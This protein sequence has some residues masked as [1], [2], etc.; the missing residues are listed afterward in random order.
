MCTR[1]DRKECA[2]SKKKKQKNVKLEINSFRN[3]L[4]LVLV[5]EMRESK[6]LAQTPMQ[7]SPFEP[8]FSRCSIPRFA[9]LLEHEHR[10]A[11]HE[12]ERRCAD[13]EPSIVNHYTNADAK[14]HC[15]NRISRIGVH[16]VS[17]SLHARARG[18]ARGF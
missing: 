7:E 12:H 5:L 8:N 1:A 14:A 10:C 3:V 9:A 16:P 17:Q 15:F 4:V 2:H 13:R 11:E 18:R 6:T